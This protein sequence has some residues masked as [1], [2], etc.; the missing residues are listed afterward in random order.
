MSRTKTILIV[1]ERIVERRTCFALY[2]IQLRFNNMKLHVL[3]KY[4]R[5][6]QN[7]ELHFVD[8][9]VKITV[10]QVTSLKKFLKI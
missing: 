9:K 10:W 2:I 3:Q 1:E 5:V 4:W 8:I 6:G 7:V